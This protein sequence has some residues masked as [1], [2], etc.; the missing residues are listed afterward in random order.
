MGI[1]AYNRGSACISRQLDAEYPRPSAESEIRDRLNAIPKDPDATNLF[2]GGV[3][4]RDR[5][6][7][8]WCL[9]NQKEKGWSSYCIPFASL[10][11][12]ARRFNIFFIGCGQDEHSF[13]W[14]FIT[15]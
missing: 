4:R 1:A 10:S 14:E 15:A 3:V 11:D 12:I 13:Y 9:M 7:K 5:N 8:D 2:Q 6:R